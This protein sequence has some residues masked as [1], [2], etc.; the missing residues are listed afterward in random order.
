MRPAAVGGDRRHVNLRD[1]AQTGE[2]APWAMPLLFRRLEA[3]EGSEPS[4]LETLALLAPVGQ[5]CPITGGVRAP[6]AWIDTHDP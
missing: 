6:G 1:N 3:A 2:L 5:R 4:L